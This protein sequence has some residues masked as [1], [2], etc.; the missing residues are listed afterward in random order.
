MTACFSR[1][2]AVTILDQIGSSGSNFTG[3]DAHT[4]QFFDD[5]PTF[6]LSAV[7]DFSV[8]SI[9]TL[10]NV[11]E[12]V[13]GFNGFTSYGNVTG[14][15]VNIYSSR[16]AAN[17]SLDGDVA[18]LLIGP[19]N[20]S[21]TASFSGDANSALISLPVNILLPRAGAFYLSVVADLDFGDGGQLGVYG[22]AGV[23][24]GFPGGL[25]GYAENPGGDF[26][27]PGNESVLGA[28]LAYRLTGD[29]V[30]EPSVR[31]LLLGAGVLFAGVRRAFRR[32]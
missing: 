24:G 21:V 18:H 1:V 29:A 2:Q 4:S 23:P 7:D 17:A 10:T 9:F 12:A 6:S 22:S 3:A 15:E 8:A 20:V 16:A 26:G 25:N 11:T 32:S 30:P 27:L 28:D 13:D 5:D 14:Y 31:A 19:A